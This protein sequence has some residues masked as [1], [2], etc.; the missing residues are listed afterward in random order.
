[1]KCIWRG[2]NAVINAHIDPRRKESALTDNRQWSVL[3]DQGINDHSQ[4]YCRENAETKKKFAGMKN[5]VNGMFHGN[6]P[7]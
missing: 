4:Y 5:L 1:V 3:Y 6:I 7:A 2:T